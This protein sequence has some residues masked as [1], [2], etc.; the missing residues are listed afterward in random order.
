MAARVGAPG[1][2]GARGV[3]RAVPGLLPLLPAAAARL[4]RAGTVRRA[5]PGWQA[6]GAAGARPAVARRGPVRSA[7]LRKRPSARPAEVG[8]AVGPLGLRCCRSY[9]SGSRRERHRE[10]GVLHVATSRARR[11]PPAYRRPTGSNARRAF[12]S[13]ASA[14]H[15]AI[16]AS[17][18]SLATRG[19]FCALRALPPCSRVPVAD[20]HACSTILG[21]AGTS[22]GVSPAHPRRRR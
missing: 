4:A 14:C 17:P 13:P 21:R 1:G 16:T 3:L 8:Q 6:A 2:A 20:H 9:S 22:R 5:P 10:M 11:A 18:N 15:D 12:L 19:K 7:P